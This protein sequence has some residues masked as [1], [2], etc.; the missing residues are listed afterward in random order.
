MTQIFV[1]LVGELVDVRRPVHAAH[2]HDDVYEIA[3][4]PYDREI[5]KWE[6][7]PGEQVV[8]ELVDSDD[9]PAL[10]AIRRA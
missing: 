4:Q 1:N 6:F 7:E 2:L 8:C 3:D 10:T 9:G 5:E